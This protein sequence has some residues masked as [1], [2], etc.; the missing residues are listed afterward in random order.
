MCSLQSF[1]PTVTAFTKVL[2][3]AI[4]SEFDPTNYPEWISDPEILSKYNYSVV[5]YQKRNSSAPF[6]I[7]KNRGTEGAVYLRYIVDHYDNFPDVAMFVHGHPE[8]HAPHWLSMLGCISPNATYMP[9]NVL[10]KVHRLIDAWGFASVWME[11]CFRDVLSIIWHVSRK[12]LV[13]LLPTTEPFEM[14]FPCCNQFILSR[15]MVHKRPLKVW[16]DLL[17][18]IN[19]QDVCHEGEPDYHLLNTTVTSGK[20]GPEMPS[21]EQLGEAPDTGYGAHTQGGA[22]EHLAHVIYGHHDLKM[23]DLTKEDYCQNFLPNCPLSP[24]DNIDSLVIP[25]FKPLKRHGGH[26]PRPKSAVVSDQGISIK[27]VG[28]A[29]AHSG[30]VLNSHRLRSHPNIPS[31]SIHTPSRGNVG[32]VPQYSH[33]NGPNRHH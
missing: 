12:Q 6:Y 18:I 27:R 11:Q 26:K 25:G 13:N 9:I 5:L 10:H 33:R 1:I 32:R 24:C 17:H 23:R 21:I 3:P 29:S 31:P 30:D 15:S 14:H 22:M 7:A 20:L 28:V 2:V 4:H 19:E 8:D 16:K